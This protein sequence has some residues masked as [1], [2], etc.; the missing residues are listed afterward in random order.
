MFSESY[1]LLVQQQCDD[2][3]SHRVK[4]QIKMYEGIVCIQKLI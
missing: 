3:Y 1:W 4:R 2:S